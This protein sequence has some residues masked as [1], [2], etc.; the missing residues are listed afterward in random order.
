MIEL[1][2]ERDKVCL[3]LLCIGIKREKKRK[4]IIFEK[5]DKGFLKNRTRIV[6]LRKHFN[7]I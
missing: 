4:L 6:N 1:G 2:K 7:L 5:S 3:C